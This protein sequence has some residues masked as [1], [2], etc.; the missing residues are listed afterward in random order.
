[1][2]SYFRWGPL[3]FYRN[4]PG[5]VYRSI[6]CVGHGQHDS[7]HNQYPS[8]PPSSPCSCV[9]VPIETAKGGLEEPNLSDVGN[10]YHELVLDSKVR[11]AIHTHVASTLEQIGAYLSKS[12]VV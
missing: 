2:G 9:E 5:D 4:T 8:S 12:L 7:C 6:N 11:L 1:M 3:P 10:A